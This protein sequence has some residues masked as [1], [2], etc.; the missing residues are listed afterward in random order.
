[1][2]VSSTAGSTRR[3]TVSSNP[4]GRRWLFA[5]GSVLLLL[6]VSLCVAQASDDVDA[7]LQRSDAPHGIVFEIVESD[8]SALEEL[9]PV[10][11]TAIQRIRVRFPQTEFAVVSH[12]R[13]EFALQTAYQGEY[14]QIHQQVQSLVA[15]DVPV[16]VCETHASWYAVSADDFPEYVDVAPT[17]PGQIQ[18]YLEMDYELI[19]IQSSN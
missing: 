13:E 2:V 8:E 16:H 4:S 1:M 10:V 12:G 7:L 17:G 19:V 6:L 3:E 11:Q 18:L 14:A 9:L 5:C 15:E